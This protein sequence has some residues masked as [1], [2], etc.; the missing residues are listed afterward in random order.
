TLPVSHRHVAVSDSVNMPSYLE[1]TAFRRAACFA[2]P[3]L[4]IAFIVISS[5]ALITAKIP[6]ML[7]NRDNLDAY[8]PLFIYFID[9]LKHGVVHYY[10]PFLFAGDRLLSNPTFQPNPAQILVGLLFGPRVIF[11]P[12]NFTY[13]L[14]PSVGF[15]GMYVFLGAICK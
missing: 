7:L 11:G 2:P 13:I 4:G 1:R 12:I 8:Y 6:F 15:L 9:G 5:A 14:E 10:D 3:V